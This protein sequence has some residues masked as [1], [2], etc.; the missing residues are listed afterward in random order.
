MTAAAPYRLRLAGLV[1]GLAGGCE[2]DVSLDESEFCTG[3]ACGDDCLSP[4]CDPDP[5]HGRGHPGVDGACRCD[6]PWGGSDCL[7]CAPLHY[8]P[9]CTPC[10]A[11]E[12]FAP[13]V[14]RDTKAG[15]GA[16][17]CPEGYLDHE[18][19]G[20][21]VIDRCGCDPLTSCAAGA[22]VAE[23]H[24]C[25]QLT[26]LVA[27]PIHAG[28]RMACAARVSWQA[29]NVGGP[30][31]EHFVVYRDGHPIATTRWPQIEDFGLTGDETYT[32][33]ITAVDRLGVESTPSIAA[34]F[35]TQGCEAA[36]D[37][38]P[39]RVVGATATYVERRCN[40]SQLQWE[41]PADAAAVSG[42]RIYLN[43]ALAHELGAVSSAIGGV[44]GLSP[45]AHY[46]YAFAPT[47][48][49]DRER[50]GPLTVVDLPPA[51]CVE[52]G[53]VKPLRTV[54]FPVRFADFVDSEPFDVGYLER[55]LSELPYS[56][57]AFIDEVSFG[58]QS[59]QIERVFDW[60]DVSD[61]VASYC[62]QIVEQNG[63]ELGFFP[64]CNTSR[65]AAV[66]RSVAGGQ[67]GIPPNDF[68]TA[69]DRQIYVVYGV[70]Q[71]AYGGGRAVWASTQFAKTETFV[72]ELGHTF[73]LRHAGTWD[74]PGATT[75]GA[76][77]RDVTAGDCE[78]WAYGDATDVMAVRLRHYSAY[79][80]LIA[81]YLQPGH[82]VI[83]E[84]GGVFGL[85]SASAPALGHRPVLLIV[86]LDN[87][88][89]YAVEYR[90]PVGFDANVAFPGYAVVDDHKPEIERGLAVWLR[91]A[92]LGE[93]LRQIPASPRGRFV[94]ADN[95]FYDPYRRIRIQLGGESDAAGVDVHVAYDAD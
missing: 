37:L 92:S 78:A 5:C 12:C 94:T 76:S 55:V 86:P 70:S 77:L 93:Q 19:Q 88:T 69:Y 74:C 81:G 59:L 28:E 39:H 18:E 79:N 21:I 6:V 34:T 33:E 3:S 52:S 42:F 14:C 10:P 31:L 82:V 45:L 7:D 13:W 4:A 49:D 89:F 27:E 32:Y 64:S 26:K 46:R 11:G 60:V 25:I 66:A 53:H 85:A 58:Q 22:V 17:V 15:D 35:D 80:K 8:G 43:G 44:D 23:G 90:E 62:T 30:A 63:R 83:A 95:D 36:V 73:G 9:L 16:C 40:T 67:H 38:A 57:A 71:G 2:V 72:H 1:V 41:P 48:G 47:Y 50:T 29:L 75:V 68:L 91:A 56:A 51:S 54:V 20:C 24:V 87:G 84:T 65:M 61:P